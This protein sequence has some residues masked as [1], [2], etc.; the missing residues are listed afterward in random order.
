MRFWDILKNDCD[1]D[2]GIKGRG[3]DKTDRAS[4]V[5]AIDVAD[6]AIV[7]VINDTGMRSVVIYGGGGE[8][9]LA[10]AVFHGRAED[11]AKLEEADERLEAIRKEEWTFRKL[12]FF[13]AF[14]FVFFCC[15]WP[16]GGHAG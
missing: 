15:G 1:G 5:L 11:V 14:F 6:D 7:K 4:Y 3:V 13:F 8:V 2:G 10:E 16:W 9:S 12:F